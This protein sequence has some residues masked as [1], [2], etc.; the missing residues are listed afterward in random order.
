MGNNYNFYFDK[1]LY[2][3]ERISFLL[4]E[5]E[6][7]EGG[8]FIELLYEFSGKYHKRNSIYHFKGDWSELA[9]EFYFSDNINAKHIFVEELLYS[10]S[11]R[12]L[13]DNILNNISDVDSFSESLGYL[14]EEVYG[15][16]LAQNELI[17]LAEEKTGVNLY[18]EI[19]YCKQQNLQNKV[20]DFYEIDDFLELSRY[21]DSEDDK[22]FALNKIIEDYQ[23]NIYQ[24]VKGTFFESEVENFDLDFSGSKSYISEKIDEHLQDLNSYEDDYEPTN[25][26]ELDTVDSILNKPSG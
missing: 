21:I 12:I 6:V 26:S 17:D 10:E 20:D 8:K 25:F 15:C 5:N 2:V 3:G 24:E 14:V 18:S 7:K 4:Q 13:I 9:S 19:V 16:S 11:N 22:Q 1:N 23:N